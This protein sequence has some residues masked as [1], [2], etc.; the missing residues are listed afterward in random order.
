MLKKVVLAATMAAMVGSAFA[1]DLC[2]QLGTAGGGNGGWKGTY[3]MSGKSYPIRMLLSYQNG[4]VYGYTLTSK[5]K[6]GYSFGNG[7]QHNGTG[8][9][10]LWANC[11]SSTLTNLH[12]VN[13][14]GTC[15]AVNN[16]AQQVHIGVN[17][18]LA[19]TIPYAG[20][21]VNTTLMPQAQQ[22]SIQ[23]NMLNQVM[24]MANNSSMSS[25]PACQ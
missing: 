12:F 11:S 10:F 22:V 13:A 20:K 6:N 23:Q 17:N 2:T 24:S 9:Y 25:L 18:P 15:G 14:A 19:M 21:N 1:S 4:M 7:G 3:V 5:D 8:N 16:N